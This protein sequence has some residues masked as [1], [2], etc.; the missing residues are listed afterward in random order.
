[1]LGIVLIALYA[2]NGILLRPALEHAV[3]MVIAVILAH[4]SARW[5]KR[6]DNTWLRNN[7]LDVLVIIVLIGVGV[8]AVGGWTFGG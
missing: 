2:L 7:F 6:E 4:V 3:T 1:L 5:N 8:A